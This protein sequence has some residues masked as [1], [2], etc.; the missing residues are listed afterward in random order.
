MSP[1]TASGNITLKEGAAT[2]AIVPIVAGVAQY[3]TSALPLGQH[4]VIAEYAGDVSHAPATSSTLIHVVSV[5]TTTT[6]MSSLN[7][8]NTGDS[9]TF[10]AT[11]T[12]AG[13]AGNVSFEDGGV[14]L[15]SV[16]LTPGGQATYITSALAAGTHSMTAT[17]AGDSSHGG[18][19]SAPVSQQ[20][21]GTGLAT[22]TSLIS[23]ANPSTAGQS[24]TFTATVTPNTATGSITFFDGATMLGSGMVDASGVATYTTTSLSVG[25]HAIGATYNGDATYASSAAPTLTQTVNQIATTTSLMTSGSPSLPA[26]SV[27]FTATVTPSTA[28][29]TVTF[30]DG[31]TSLGAAMLS[32]GTAMY[33]TSSLSN[34]SHTITATYD[35][36]SSYAT[37]TSSPV[38][39]QVSAAPLLAT[40]TTMASSNN[41]S[42][43]G[44]FVTLTAT[45]TPLGATGTVTFVD[46][47]FV[48]GTVAVG[49]NG[50]ASIVTSSLA[51]GPHFITANYSGDATYASS[52]SAPFMQTVNAIPPVAVATTTTLTAAPNPAFG[53]TAV[54]LTATVTP[55]GVTGTVSFF[56]NGTPVATVNLDSNG[57]AIATIPSIDPGPHQL[58]AIYNGDNVHDRSNSNVFLLDGLSP[59]A[60][61]ADIPTL[62]PRA[63]LVLALALGAASIF[64]LKR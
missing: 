60:G 41:P 53:G 56:D 16:A 47:I 25:A 64:V 27:T 33:A 30:Y 23:S 14:Q 29:G 24:V 11:V 8:S 55:A 37:S 49:L 12:P 35:G 9:V 7:P 62:D 15:V 44:Q 42:Q 6:L 51:V 63:L 1:P 22:S 34:G 2:L 21:I 32:G 43:Q 3:T 13:G 54:T 4:S 28:T 26:Q 48:L 40:T 39:Q 19:T 38:T 45:V 20:V 46:G 36:D 10:T 61:V 59:P 18:S 50:Q 52:A 57:Q 58:T 17:Y 31:A 5:A